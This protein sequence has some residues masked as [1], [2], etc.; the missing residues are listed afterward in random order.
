MI[1]ET[2]ELSLNQKAAIEELLGYAL[3]ERETISLRT[4]PREKSAEQKAA[5]ANL[6]KFLAA[7][8]RPRPGVS[9]EELEAAIL[10]ALRSERPR[11]TPMQ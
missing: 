3:S 4:L 7:K 10:E 11:Y 5:A 9:D 1:I 2:A 8:R 6:V